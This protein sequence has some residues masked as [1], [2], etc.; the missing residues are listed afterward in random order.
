MPRVARACLARTTT[1]SRCPRC[2]RSWTPRRRTTR[3]S[4]RR[5]FRARLRRNCRRAT[6]PTS[7]GRNTTTTGPASF[8]FAIGLLALLNQAGLRMGAALAA[9]VPGACRLPVS[10]LRPRGVAAR[11]Y[12]L[13]R[14]PAR[15]RGAAAPF[16]RVTARDLRP[17]RMVGAGARRRTGW[18]RA[19]VSAGHRDRRRRAAD[20]QP[21]HRQHQGPV[22]DRDDAYA[23]GARRHRRR[24]GALAG[25]A[26]RSARA[27]ASP[28]GCGR[29]ASCWSV[30]FCSITA[31]PEVP[32]CRRQIFRRRTRRR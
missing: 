28:A 23:A 14:K 9:A 6:P 19:G 2:R 24:L 4:R 27:A 30:L 21:R 32:R 13:P 1:R 7:P 18:P 12:R 16:L 17:V 20:A 15:R 25:A 11:R 29:S 26:A 5:R 3:A 8:V 22:A 31:R 10:A